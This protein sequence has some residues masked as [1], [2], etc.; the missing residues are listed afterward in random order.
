VIDSIFES[1]ENYDESGPH[2]RD[3][4]YT[5]YKRRTG[6]DPTNVAL[7]E[8]EGD[9]GA[10]HYHFMWCAEDENGEPVFAR[11]IP[12][13]RCWAEK[14]YRT[15]EGANKGVLSWAP[16]L[17]LVVGLGWWMRRK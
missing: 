1:I 7:V 10:K 11:A 16:T 2:W 9:N 6:I 8:T 4:M 14:I 15:G 12:W 5:A 13:Y 3:M 17:L